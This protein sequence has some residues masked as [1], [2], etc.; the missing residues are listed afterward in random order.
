MPGHL[1]NTES[2]RLNDLVADFAKVG[3][4][5]SWDISSKM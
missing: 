4:S 5:M 3:E 1:N 2:Y